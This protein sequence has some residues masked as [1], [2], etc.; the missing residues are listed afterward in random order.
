MCTNQSGLKFT[1]VWTF[2]QP[3]PLMTKNERICEW[4]AI[5]LKNQVY[6]Q[7]MLEYVR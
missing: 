3:V 1:M 4:C 7:W 5:N 2:Q 6:S